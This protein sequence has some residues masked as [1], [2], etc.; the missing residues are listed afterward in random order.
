MYISKPLIKMLKL[1]KAL[2]AMCSDDDKL[3]TKLFNFI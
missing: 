2:L 3:Y 1:T